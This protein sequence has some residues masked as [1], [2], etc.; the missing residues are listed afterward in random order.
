MELK[1]GKL[2]IAEPFMLDP[3]FKRAV[4][5]I[6]EHAAHGTTGFILNKLLDIKIGDLI[7][8]FPD[9]KA[10]VQIG[11]PVAV[12][13]VHYLHN[14]GDLLD[15]SIEVCSGVYWGG[16]FEK[17]KFLIENG[18]IKEDNIRFFVGYSGWSD[19]QLEEELKDSSWLIDEMDANYLFKVKPFVLW[20]TV[21]HN[22]GNTYSVIA[23]MPDSVSLN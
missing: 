20:Q 10:R 22:K 1:A 2:L 8:D 6:C 19:N 7:S 16:D 18:L 3:N 11:G 5:L 13:S 9:F 14:V 21:L 12:D 15:D 17:L 23:Q 4:I